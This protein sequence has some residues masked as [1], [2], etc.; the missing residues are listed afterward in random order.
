MVDD[1]LG[2]RPCFAGLDALVPRVINFGST[3]NPTVSEPRTAAA[4]TTAFPRFRD[5]AACAAFRPDG[6]Y[7]RG[8][9]YLY[10]GVGK[11]TKEENN[12][13][14]L[15]SYMLLALNL[16]LQAFTPSDHL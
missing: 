7:P 4:T 8:S 6:R 3:S 2:L 15:F 13:Q 10:V 16:R 12:H 9:W 5:G 14:L 1:Y 11:I